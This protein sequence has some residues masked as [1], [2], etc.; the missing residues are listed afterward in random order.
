[1]IGL[2]HILSVA[3][4]V[5]SGQAVAL[6]PLPPCEGEESGMFVYGAR[7]FGTEDSGFVIEG[8][9]N[10]DKDGVVGGAPGPL[11]E[12]DNF[13]GSRI[14]DCGSGHFVALHGAYGEI[15]KVLGATEFLR[16]K[17]QV[18]KRFGIADV[19]KAARAVYGDDAFVR[20]VN[21][22]ETEETCAC[23]DFF[24]GQWK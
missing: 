20:M 13:N 4:M 11:S 6:T 14:V 5:L 9:R 23:R 17:I 15:E 24:P 22:R 10:L 8:Y 7:Y 21:L 12:L 19:R 16:G 2:R 1:M 18:G 3:T